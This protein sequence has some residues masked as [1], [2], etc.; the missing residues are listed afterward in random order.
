MRKAVIMLFGA[1]VLSGCSLNNMVPVEVCPDIREIKPPA[2]KAVLVIAQT[3]NE[4][5]YDF[6]DNPDVDNYLDRKFIG[7]L[8]NSSFFITAVEPG[9][10]F[11]IADSEGYETILLDFR[12][13][14]TYY[15]EQEERMGYALPRTNYVL[16]K[17]DHLYN[18]LKGKCT[19]YEPDL[20]NPGRDLDEETFAE[21]LAAHKKKMGDTPANESEPGVNPWQ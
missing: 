16:V 11:V 15:L 21:V 10:H 7:K 19:C 18:D 2:G 20:Q 6:E 12:A 8:K 9:R 3:M 4:E 17:A 5:N 1:V 13:G 14:R